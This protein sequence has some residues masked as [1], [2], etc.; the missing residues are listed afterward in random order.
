MISQQSTNASGV[1]R[2]S[3]GSLGSRG[4]GDAADFFVSRLSSRLSGATVLAARDEASEDEEEDDDEMRRSAVRQSRLLG[5]RAAARSSSSGQRPSRGRLS[6]ERR[7][8]RRSSD[9]SSA[10]ASGPRSNRRRITRSGS[11]PM[12]TW[13]LPPAVSLPSGRVSSKE[14]PRARE[15]QNEPAVPRLDIVSAARG[16]S[17]DRKGAMMPPEGVEPTTPNR[18]KRAGLRWG[19]ARMHCGRKEMPQRGETKREVRVMR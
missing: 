12:G 2:R 3:T 1:S 18:K 16:S 17:H 15:S 5:E 6:L 14:L 4:S 13:A 10:S 9:D 7:T 11:D 8:P 19:K